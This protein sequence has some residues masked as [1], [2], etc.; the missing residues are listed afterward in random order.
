MCER[1]SWHRGEGQKKGTMGYREEREN[2]IAGII[3]PVKAA[4]AS[5]LQRVMVGTVGIRPKT[6]HGELDCRAVLAIVLGP[7][8]PCCGDFQRMCATWCH[9]LLHLSSA[10]VFLQLILGC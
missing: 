1:S 9:N 7:C 4:S 5:R 10:A 2:G 8:I 6:V 3:C